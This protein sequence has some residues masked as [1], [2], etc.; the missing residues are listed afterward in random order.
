VYYSIKVTTAMNPAESVELATVEMI[1]MQNFYTGGPDI[2]FLPGD[3]GWADNDQ[4]TFAV[5]TTATKASFVK[6][7]DRLY[8]TRARAIDLPVNP[9]PTISDALIV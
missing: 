6:N 5:T 7:I 1:P 9:V 4:Y 8:N 2:G 3:V